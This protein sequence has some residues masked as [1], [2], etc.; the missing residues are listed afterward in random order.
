MLGQTSVSCY[1]EKNWK[2]GWELKG[3]A[4]VMSR[5]TPCALWFC[6][7]QVKGATVVRG[8]LYLW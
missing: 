8:T 2:K 4:A 5:G 6:T 7:G 3:A 1:P